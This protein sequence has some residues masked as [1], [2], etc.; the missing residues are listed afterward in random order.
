[1][2]HLVDSEPKIPWM[3]IKQEHI[4]KYG[5]SGAVIK[6]LRIKMGL[7]AKSFA[8]AL[9]KN[10][11]TINR[12]EN[13]DRIGIKLSKDL[14]MFFGLNDWRTL[15]ENPYKSEINISDEH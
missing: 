9:H 1:M 10:I 7:S 6:H 2:L 8:R 12:I 4:T 11:K 13:S 15:R 3:E 14:Q 5:Y